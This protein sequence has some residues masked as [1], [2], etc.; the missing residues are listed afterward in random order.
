MYYDF[1]A[2]QCYSNKE[3]V[4]YANVYIS[5][6]VFKEIMLDAVTTCL[7]NLFHNLLTLIEKLSF[8]VFINM[9][10]P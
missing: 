4:P 3:I 7:H 5:R 6:G 1:L 10:I 9:H 8:I 2:R